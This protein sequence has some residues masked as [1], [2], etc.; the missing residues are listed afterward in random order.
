MALW[1]SMSTLHQYPMFCYFIEFTTLSCSWEEGPV[2]WIPASG[3]ICWKVG[4]EGRDSQVINITALELSDIGLGQGSPR[5]L[6]PHCSVQRG[7]PKNNLSG[8]LGPKCWPCMM[9]FPFSSFLL[10]S[11]PGIP[12]VP[13]KLIPCLPG[14]TTHTTAGALPGYWPSVCGGQGASTPPITTTKYK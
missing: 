2:F 13:L 1:P 6:A 4:A 14:L 10:A 7:L 3:S 5:Q 9:A 12:V 8:L 11:L